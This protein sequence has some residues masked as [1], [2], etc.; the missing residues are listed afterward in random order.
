MGREG[1]QK[2]Q[3]KGDVIYGRLFRNVVVICHLSNFVE[4]DF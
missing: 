2:S 1:G 4:K 3:K